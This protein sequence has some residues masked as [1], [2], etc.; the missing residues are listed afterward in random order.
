MEL[1]GVNRPLNPFKSFKKCLITCSYPLKNPVLDGLM[2]RMS[3]SGCDDCEVLRHHGV[4]RLLGPFHHRYRRRLA[5][6]SEPWHL[7]AYGQA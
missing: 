1:P 7:L 2:G 6:T 5:V 4:R 3:A